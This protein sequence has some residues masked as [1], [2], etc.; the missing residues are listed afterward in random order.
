MAIKL[1][2]QVWKTYVPYYSKGLWGYADTGGKIKVK[3]F[4]R[5]RLGFYNAYGFAEITDSMEQVG[6]IGSSLRT[7]VKPQ[8]EDI[9]VIHGKFIKARNKNLNFELFNNNGIRLLSGDYEKIEFTDYVSNYVFVFKNDYSIYVYMLDTK[10]GKLVFKRKHTDG[11]KLKFM[12]AYETSLNKQLYTVTY[13]YT[14]ESVTYNLVTG[15]IVKDA[16][17][18]TDEFDEIPNSDFHYDADAVP[19]APMLADEERIHKDT[20]RYVNLPRLDASIKYE[21]EVIC[22]YNPNLL[23]VRINRKWGIVTSNR[24][25]IVPAIYDSILMEYYHGYYS[26]SYNQRTLL[27]ICKK[28]GLIGMLSTDSSLKIPIIYKSIKKFG[29]QYFMTKT[30]AGYGVVTA[31]GTTLIPNEVDSFKY[32]LGDLYWQ[33]CNNELILFAVK[34]DKYALYSTSG[35]KTEYEFDKIDKVTLEYGDGWFNIDALALLKNK[36]YGFA[37][38]HKN[39]FILMPCQYLSYRYCESKIG[40]RHFLYVQLKEDLWVYVDETGRKYYDE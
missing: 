15:Q 9:N 36:L 28:D 20:D 5:H 35:N 38:C 33:Y 2:A 11:A 26:S 19:M 22:Y 21:R 40:N 23:K 27:W 18:E 17:G 10:T 31:Q 3:P 4:T 39:G 12:D 6:L 32:V 7:V 25:V 24:R 34:D 13:H 16:M 14:S 37:F 29:S 8:F 1:N 30:S